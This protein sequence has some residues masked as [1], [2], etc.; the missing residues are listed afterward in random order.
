MICFMAR[1]RASRI[2]LIW[3]MGGLQGWERGGGHVQIFGNPQRAATDSPLLVAQF[4]AMPT[5]GIQQFVL[6]TC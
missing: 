1:K 2:Y 5:D 6:R 4:S 3:G